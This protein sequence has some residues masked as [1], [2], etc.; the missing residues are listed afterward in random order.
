MAVQSLPWNLGGLLCH[1]LA[2]VF[3]YILCCPQAVRLMCL[4]KIILLSGSPF[5]K[6]VIKIDGNSA[7][8]S[9]Q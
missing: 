8:L 7:L 9:V 4:D 2:L 5:R 1:D 6:T 3:L